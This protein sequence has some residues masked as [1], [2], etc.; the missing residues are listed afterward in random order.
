MGV[1]FRAVVVPTYAQKCESCHGYWGS[2]DDPSALW[3][4]FVQ[5]GAQNL[6]QPGEPANS[7]FYTKMLS[8]DHPDFPSGKRMPY[9]A[10]SVSSSE[11]SRLS[12][13]IND[14]A[15]EEGFNAYTEIHE[16]F[17]Y[18]CKNCHDYFGASSVNDMYETLL[19]SEVDGMSLLVPGDANESL[20]YVKLAGGEQPFGETMP[21]YYGP[22]ADADLGLIEQWIQ[23]GAPDN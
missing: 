23:A 22:I 20:L 9:E 2:S 3:D 17:D 18:Q 8:T 13:W 15:L 12:T 1:S 11:L 4:R 5:D 21:L 6:I 7:V 10:E 16:E 19:A 14:G